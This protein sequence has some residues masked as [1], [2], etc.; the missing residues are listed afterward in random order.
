[1]T[2]P[3]VPARFHRHRLLP[4]L[5]ALAALATPRIPESVDDVYI[6][7]DYARH[8]VTTGRLEWTT[9]ERVEGYSSL[10]SVALAAGLHLLGV[11]P[12]VALKGIAAGSVVVLGVV[13]DRV[14]ARSWTGTAAL[15]GLL[16]ASPTVRWAVDGM[17][18]PL[19]AL[20]LSA[21]W[22]GVMRGRAGIG[23]ALLALSG[24]V[25]P[26]G[27]TH[28]A[29]VLGLVMW[30]IGFR[31]TLARALPT[32]VALVAYHTLRIAW[33]GDFV[34]T[35]TLLKIVAT[36]AS[37]YGLRQGVLDAAPYL[38]VLLLVSPRWG[39]PA[40][41][42]TLPLLIQIAVETSAS[43]DWMAGGRLVM[44]GAI[45]T[46][47]LLAAIRHEQ[48]EVSWVRGGMGVALA[49][50]GVAL[51]PASWGTAGAEWQSFPNL[52]R[53]AAGTNR[54]LVTPLPEDVA[55]IVE[56]V[57]EGR[58]VLVND[59]G[60]VGGIPGVCILDMRGLVT[61]AS[62]EAAG[63]GRQDAWFRELLASAPRPFAVRQAW[64]GGGAKETPEWLVEQYA[65][66][67]DLSYPGG[68]VG[69]FVDT[70]AK[71]PLGVI[72]ERWQ[73]L[74]DQ[75]PDHPWIAWRAA[76]AA[77]NAG[78]EDE[79]HAL[80]RRAAARWP[81][82]E[83]VA[84]DASRWSFVGGTVPLE[85][86]AG[87][88]FV[89]V[90][91]GMLETRGVDCLGERLRVESSERVEVEITDVGTGVSVT[92]AT[93]SRGTTL[94]FPACAGELA[95]GRGYQVRVVDTEPTVRTILRVDPL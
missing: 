16:L 91:T 41:V 75:H 52:S 63:E 67:V 64:W 33:F 95:G 60:M 71:L 8:W 51:L 50:L 6:L 12:E 34:P 57:P 39:V 89:V 23:F 58:C 36:P 46:A 81:E 69:W 30:Q 40:A 27:V 19:F 7:A 17:D 54:G 26:E 42:A 47:I 73:R 62:A 21:G 79:A 38:G 85:W 2:K 43:G 87:R 94:E 53:L 65:T 45:A 66:R 80:A 3:S 55:W 61:R 13:A 29:V 10:V 68:T 72:A 32:V 37:L 4:A 1:M 83:M 18:A 48:R 20:A 35:P 78:D 92:T 70:E 14:F 25:R 22:L 84:D 56:R 93:D 49:F 44:P 90:G 15:F 88:G 31:R 82:V 74:A 59:V 9:G 5:A 76:I 28:L 77:N 24:L 11:A 86:E